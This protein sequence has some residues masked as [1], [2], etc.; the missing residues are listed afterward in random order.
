MQ[1]RM[2]SQEHMILTKGWLF[3]FQCHISS[4]SMNSSASQLKIHSL[5]LSGETYKSIQ[6]TILISFTV[7]SSSYKMVEF[8]CLTLCISLSFYCRNFMPHQPVAIQESRRPQQGY[9][10]TSRAAQFI[11]MFADSSNNASIVN[12]PIIS[13]GNQLDYLHPSLYQLDHGKTFNSISLLV[14][15][16]TGGIQP[17][18]WLLIDF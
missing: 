2:L 5:S 11:R 15:H 10:R 8:S 12:I 17:Y 3:L 16:L 7:M 1:S 14:Y 9:K 6:P 4:L 18:W 13:L